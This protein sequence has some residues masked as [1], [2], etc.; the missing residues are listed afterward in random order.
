MNYIV[1]FI[2]VIAPAGLELM[3]APA[4]EVEKMRQAD[5]QVCPPLERVEATERAISDQIRKL[6][7]RVN[8]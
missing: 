4:T 6:S 8:S 3:I 2:T 5:R 1:V 7:S